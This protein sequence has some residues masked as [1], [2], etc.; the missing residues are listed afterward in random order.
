MSTL[1]LDSQPEYNGRAIHDA[2][3]LRFDRGLGGASWIVAR[4]TPAPGTCNLTMV[5]A[6]GDSETGAF[7]DAATYQP[8]PAGQV[9]IGFREQ[10]SWELVASLEDAAV[11]ARG[12][13]DWGEPRTISL[14]LLKPKDLYDVFTESNRGQAS[15][16]GGG[17]IVARYD[18]RLEGRNPF[19]EVHLIPD[20]WQ[21]AV[22]PA[23]DRFRHGGSPFAEGTSIAE[24]TSLLQSENPLLAT[25]AFRRLEQAGTGDAAT[26]ENAILSGAGYRRGVFA[27]LVLSLTEDEE[28]A[29]TRLQSIIRQIDTMEDHRLLITGIATASA[30]ADPRS[31][32]E[33][34]AR[35]L[36]DEERAHLEQIRGGRELDP[37]IRS[38][39][40]PE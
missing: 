22:R 31:E 7:L 5:G 21:E 2:A 32:R 39:L 36:I 3:T 11:A 24:L 1:P 18:E 4:V 19:S 30:L 14:D 9:R 16:A 38:M 23:F 28:L 13:Y 10:G 6:V 33:R 25:A 12:T 34:V 17:V 26:L 15:T 40:Y 29:F 8:I 20:A 35:C 37:Y 27:Y